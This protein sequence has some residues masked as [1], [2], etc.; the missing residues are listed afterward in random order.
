M[1]QKPPEN[2]SG[3][4]P[5]RDRPFFPHCDAADELLDGG[6]SAPNH[7][8]GPMLRGRDPVVRPGRNVWYYVSSGLA[9]RTPGRFRTWV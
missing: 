9:T 5:H 3:F 4:P 8:S 2:G 6:F 1:F 7:A